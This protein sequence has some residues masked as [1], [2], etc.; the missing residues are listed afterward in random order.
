MKT[1]SATVVHILMGIALVTVLGCGQHLA[2]TSNQNFVLDFGD[3]NQSKYVELKNGDDDSDFCTALG[4]IKSHHGICDADFESK[5]EP[6]KHKHYDCSQPT[7][8]LRTDKVTKSYVAKNAPAAGDPNVMHKIQSNDP[9][10]I[11]AV[12]DTFKS[13]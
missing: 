11:T 4:K 2:P 5:S 1:S 8:C 7:V 10:D 13:P 3:P 12:L 6:R 9:A